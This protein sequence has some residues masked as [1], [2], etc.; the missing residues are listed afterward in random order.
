M[1]SFLVKDC[2]LAVIATGQSAASITVMKEL[3][4]RIPISSIYYHFWGE[5]IRPSFVHP[6]YL[7]DFARWAYKELHD[8]VLSERLAIIDPSDFP[9]FENLRRTLIDIFDRRIDE[10]DT[11]LVLKRESKFQF[12][13]SVMTI[14]ETPLKAEN[15][16]DLK[17]VI[18]HISSGSIFF[19]F[20]DARSR[21]ANRTDDFSQWLLGYGDK[22][23]ETV[24]KLSHIDPYFYTL[25]QIKH[26]V[27]KILNDSFK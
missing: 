3:L 25:T 5:R 23:I 26:E 9:D 13:R 11:I 19:H 2:A 15:P 6:E 1:G 24:K 7:N 10:T 4:A 18:P 17:A 16:P 8:P 12:L 20:I 14:F 22:Y 21:T 27:I